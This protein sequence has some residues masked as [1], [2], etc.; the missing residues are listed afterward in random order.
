MELC[1][2]TAIDRPHKYTSGYARESGKC[3]YRIQRKELIEGP[4]EPAAEEVAEAVVGEAGRETL[5]V[6]RSLGISRLFPLVARLP[7]PTTTFTL[8]PE[9]PGWAG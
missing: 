2:V 9:H 7:G 6:F 8:H 4:R 3:R 1:Q 5:E